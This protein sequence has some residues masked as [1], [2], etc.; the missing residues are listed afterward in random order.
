MEAVVASGPQPGLHGIS[1]GD[2]GKLPL[3]EGP[4]HKCCSG[5][6]TNKGHFCSKVFGPEKRNVETPNWGVTSK[7]YTTAVNTT[8]GIALLVFHLNPNHGISQQ[9][10]SAVLL[11][12]RRGKSKVQDREQQEILQHLF[13][14]LWVFPCLCW[15][16]QIPNA[17]VS[18]PVVSL[19][20]W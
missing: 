12:L 13:V 15:R 14:L 6:I 1:A 18:I 20:R 4:L 5:K 2:E 7:G 16:T 9:D 8:D 19:L 3:P 10:T 17:V 11:S